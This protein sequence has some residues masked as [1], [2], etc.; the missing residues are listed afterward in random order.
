VMIEETS[1]RICALYSHGTR[2]S[3]VTLLLALL[4]ILRM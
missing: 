3:T 1:C 2:N 4:N